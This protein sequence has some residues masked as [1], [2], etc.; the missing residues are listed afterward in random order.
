MKSLCLIQTL[1]LFVECLYRKE[2]NRTL[3]VLEF[4]LVLGRLIKNTTIN[5]KYPT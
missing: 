5:E 1:S 2:K 4:I 3:L